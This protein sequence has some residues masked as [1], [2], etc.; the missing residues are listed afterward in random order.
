MTLDD[1]TR[2]LLD[3]IAAL[4]A[5]PTHLLP[6]ADARAAMRAR[7]AR[8]EPGPRMHVRADVDVPV[9]GGR[10]RMR[11]LSPAP[12]A[13]AVLVFLHGGGWALGDLDGFEPLARTLAAATGCTVVLPDYRLAPEHPF[14]AALTDAEAALRWVL[15]HRAEL[16]T[17]GAPVVVGG[18]SSG[19]NLAAV[20]CRRAAGQGLDVAAQVLVYPVTD[21]DLE[22]PSYRAEENQTLVGRDAMAWFWD[23]YLPDRERRTDP[24][25]APLHAPSLAGLP[26]AVVLTA[27]HDVLRDEGEAYVDRLR[28][29][30]V[31]VRHRRFAGQMHGF[32]GQIGVLPGSDD[33]VAFVAESLRDLLPLHL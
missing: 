10:V 30:G 8:L 18:D 26:P 12:H 23:L 15:A 31:E 1:A 22:R 25:A 21:S 17:A 28:E 5:P 3:R 4:G 2:A 19:G 24:D 13:P 9:D 33:G 32:L 29:A 27:E 14:P 11:I 6:V 16:A 7:Q 20:L